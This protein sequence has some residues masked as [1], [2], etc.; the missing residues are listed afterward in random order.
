MKKL[1]H[2]CENEFIV[3]SK[4]YYLTIT[5]SEK[6]DL[7]LICPKCDEMV[8]FTFIEKDDFMQLG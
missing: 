1:C 7:Q 2:K 8:E 6:I 4:D 5:E 3:K